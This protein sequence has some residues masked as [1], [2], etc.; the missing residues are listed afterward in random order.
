MY[1][2]KVL[3]KRKKLNFINFFEQSERYLVSQKLFSLYISKYRIN[4]WFNDLHNYTFFHK[5]FILKR[6]RFWYS[7]A[8]RESISKYHD[9][10]NML[11]ASWD[12]NFLL[13]QK[14]LFFF[15]EGYQLFFILRNNFNNLGSLKFIEAIET[16]VLKKHG[17][18]VLIWKIIFFNLLS[19]KFICLIFEFFFFFQYNLL[20]SFIFLTSFYPLILYSFLKTSEYSY[21]L[22]KIRLRL[23]LRKPYLNNYNIFFFTNLFIYGFK[24]FFVYS[25]KLNFYVNSFFGYLLLNKLYNF[26][27]KKSYIIFF[28]ITLSIVLFFVLIICLFLIQ[29]INILVFYDFFYKIFSYDIF[30]LFNN[31]FLNFVFLYFIYLFFNFV[32]LQFSY[33]NNNILN[34]IVKYFFSNNFIIFINFLNKFLYKQNYISNF[35]IND[36]NEQLNILKNIKTQQYINSYNF[37]KKNAI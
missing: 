36:I 11:T 5:Y 13:Q 35:Y 22:N 3:K 29:L 12:D 23:F 34:F 37:L 9:G 10:R 18:L 4:S 1:S 2:Y 17:F 16:S 28:K 30:I 26:E 19:I 33:I 21:K 6:D 31:M 25:L 24:R 27:K 8:R 14:S 15:K 20:L 7:V 32:I